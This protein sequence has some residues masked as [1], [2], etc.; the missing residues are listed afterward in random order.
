MTRGNDESVV[1]ESN[2]VMQT[3]LVIAALLLA[4]A[5][6][7]P[8]DESRQASE[9]FRST[10]TM[11]TV[12]ALV[13]DHSGQFVPNLNA[14]DFELY[15]NGVRQSVRI[16]DLQEEPMALVVVVQTG[17]RAIRHFLDYVDLPLFLDWLTGSTT[18]ELML[19]TFDSRVQIVWH[20][21]VRSDGEAHS[22][23]RLTRGDHGA[24][25]IDAVQL[26]VQQ[27]QSEPGHFRRIV[28]LISQKK[29]DGSATA[30]E[31]VLRTLGTGSTAIYSLTFD[32]AGATSRAKR[33]RVMHRPDEPTPLSAAVNNIR[34]DT[35]EE[36]SAYTGACICRFPRGVILMKP[37]RPLQVTFA[38][39]TH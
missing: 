21:P 35:A 23:T 39:A 31:E 22:L 14:G 38:T 36:L 18:H 34:E 10:S 27:L 26:A 12:P 3:S 11:V 13:R 37:S 15:D 17:G 4:A 30:A 1:R 19:V 24:A 32:A 16:A 5:T 8:Q 6:A 25:L 28:L 29:D 9:V 7:T 20:F 2:P 33:S